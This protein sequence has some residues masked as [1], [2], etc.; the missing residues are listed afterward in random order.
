MKQN[1]THKLVSIAMLAAIGYLLMFI[2]FPVIP[3]F[4]FMK[5]DFSEIPILIGAYL[6]GP[7]AAVMT[8][9]I[10]SLLHFLTTGGDVGA[11]IGDTTSFF[12]AL[13]FVL[14]IYYLS[15]RSHS[16]KS[17][18]S[19]L[20]VGTLVM[21]VTMMIVN[22]TIALPLYLKFVHL[23]LGMGFIKYVIIGVAPFNLI[24]GSLLTVFFLGIHERLLPALLKKQYI[25]K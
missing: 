25:K 4:P 23:D 8:A 13:S 1:K 20:I 16:K 24:K 3:A 14:P 17:L 18:I 2:A 7:G 5:V 15:R 6:F 21:T 22:Y 11:L 19:A 12:A 10:R 9:F